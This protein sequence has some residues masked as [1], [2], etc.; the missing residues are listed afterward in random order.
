MKAFLKIKTLPPQYQRHTFYLL[1]PYS[2]NLVE[3]ALVQISRRR[4]VI[5]WIIPFALNCRG[6]Q[7]QV[8]DHLHE[9]M[10]GIYEPAAE[11]EVFSTLK[12]PDGVETN[13]GSLNLTLMKDVGLG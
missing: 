6:H 5:S 7:V 1:R 3:A 10:A 8:S 2:Q 4:T 12:D 11:A 9:S 13:L